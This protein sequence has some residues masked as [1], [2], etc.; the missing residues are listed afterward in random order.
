[1]INF[2]EEY[3]YCITDHRHTAIVAILSTHWVPSPWTKCQIII[4]HRFL[5]AILPFW[6]ISAIAFKD[7]RNWTPLPYTS[8]RITGMLR[9]MQPFCVYKIC[10][11]DRDIFHINHKLV[12]DSSSNRVEG[13]HFS[14]KIKTTYSHSRRPS[15]E[16]QLRNVPFYTILYH[17]TIYSFIL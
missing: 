13:R 4:R 12:S 1:M 17:C 8:W 7:D 2:C 15:H 5:R 3:N 6:L 10:H 11:F 9:V 16:F 14:W